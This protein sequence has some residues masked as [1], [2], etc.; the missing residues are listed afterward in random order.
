[1]QAR[2]RRDASEMQATTRAPTSR[3]RARCTR[4]PPPTR[5][6]ASLL[7]YQSAGRSKSGQLCSATEQRPKARLP[8]CRFASMGG[9]LRS[10]L[11]A[12]AWGE[13]IGAPELGTP[14]GHRLAIG[15]AEAYG[16]CSDVEDNL[17]RA[18]S[19]RGR[20]GS[21]RRGRHR[22]LAGMQGVVCG[23]ERSEPSDPSDH[24]GHALEW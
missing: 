15:V 12:V 5:P 4:P 17:G 23:T 11:V 2:C 19:E 10:S 7:A 22:W 14:S 18:G 6:L 16:R 9:H 20:N 8:T 24:A 3:L 1:M 21:A 13:L